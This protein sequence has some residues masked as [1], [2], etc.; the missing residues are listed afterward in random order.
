MYINSTKLVYF[1]PTKSTE[2]IV[3]GIAQGIHAGT[4]E[5]LDLTPPEA[6]ESVYEELRDELAV[7]GAPVYGGRIPPEAVRRLR[8]IRA[9]NTPA[10]VV[11]VYGNRAYEDALLELRDL[12]ADLGFRPIAGGAFVAVHSYDSVATPIASGRPDA[13][14][15]EKAEEFGRSVR[16]K[17]QTAHSLDEMAPL[18]VPGE[19]PYKDLHKPPDIVPITDRTLC[20]LCQVCADVCPTAAIK[21]SSTIVT[22]PAACIQCSACIKS[23]WAG[24]RSWDSSWIKDI[25]EWLSTNYRQRKE[26]EI[27]L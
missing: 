9:N 23:C 26:P 21:V 8:R 22:D 12:A 15:L 16:E 3:K 6:R 24:A 10:V 11:V 7:I 4:V 5:D 1:S 17:I 2:K 27:Y 19:F 18:Q 14:D 25:S 13:G 20:A